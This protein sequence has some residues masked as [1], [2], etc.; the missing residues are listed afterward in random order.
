MPKVLVSQECT[1][2]F[3]H[4]VCIVSIALSFS[5]GIV[6]IGNFSPLYTYRVFKNASTFENKSWVF[7]MYEETLSF[8]VQTCSCRPNFFGAMNLVIDRTLFLPNRTWRI[9]AERTYGLVFGPTCSANGTISAGH[10]VQRNIWSITRYDSNSARNT[11]SFY[12]T[13]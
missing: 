11:R 13:L 3:K 12:P 10:S 9:S 8:Q 4:P 7:P 5:S 2:F 1:L 6:I